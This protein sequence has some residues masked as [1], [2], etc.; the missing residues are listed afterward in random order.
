VIES[1]YQHE[2]DVCHRF[3]AGL[4]ATP[5]PHALWMRDD[6]VTI[7]YTRERAVAHDYLAPCILDKLSLPYSS[8]AVLHTIKTMPALLRETLF[9]TGGTL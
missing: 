2:G 5:K 4:S 6:S 8:D 9:P 3:V 7:E 1:I